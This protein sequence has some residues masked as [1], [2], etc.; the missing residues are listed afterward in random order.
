M[1]KLLLIIVI[2][3]ALVLLLAPGVVGGLT[4]RRVA[5][6]VDAVQDGLVHYPSV[7]LATDRYE[8]GWFSSAMS[9]TI[10]LPSTDGQDPARLHVESTVAHGLLAGAARLQLARVDS[11]VHLEQ[12]G[13][14]LRLPIDITTD[15]GLDGAATTRVTGTR[16]AHEDAQR[17]QRV[18]WDG[19]ELLIEVSGDAARLKVEGELAA[20]EARDGISD[21][22]I[23]PL[24]VSSRQARSA[25]GLW[26][27]TGELTLGEL[28]LT[29]LGEQVLLVQDL[30]LR[31][32]TV[33]A[34]ETIDYHLELHGAR[35]A[36][37]NLRQGRFDLVME[38]SRL[39]PT[40][41]ARLTREMRRIANTIPAGSAPPS[42]AWAEPDAVAMLRKGAS[43]TVQP[44]AFASDHGNFDAALALTV[45]PD[46]RAQRVSDLMGSLQGSLNLRA[47]KDLLETLAGVQPEFGS[48]AA[49]LFQ[50]G[51][52]AED[53]DDFTIEA[54][55]RNGL[56]TINGL[57]LPLAF[58]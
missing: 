37:G 51:L 50:A 13:E 8:R 43:L 11:I 53:G 19:G 49:M 52:L 30:H 14:R 46:P 6:Y 10:T 33:L 20:L 9:Q 31:A 5:D 44:L 29:T 27:G 38:L 42:L 17:E 28:A 26:T 12:N 24:S 18:S 15:F 56:L 35:I 23:G 3:T 34:A 1:R 4:E 32:S 40:P 48:T 39:D 36:S 47:S 54:R 57:P 16:L 25:H 58:Y 7:T 21:V 22:V 2:V 45:S 55:Y 41:L